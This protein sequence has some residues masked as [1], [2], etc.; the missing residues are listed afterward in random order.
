MGECLQRWIESRGVVDVVPAIGRRDGVRRG[1]ADEDIYFPI[2]GRGFL[3][4]FGS[5]E[6]A[7][8]TP[9]LER[10]GLELEFLGLELGHF[11]GGLAGATGDSVLQPRGERLGLG[12]EEVEPGV[13][14]VEGEEAVGGLDASAEEGRDVKVDDFDGC[15][16]H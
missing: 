1:G 3:V 16:V 10:A 9:N 14:A 4:L 12:F 5:P 7:T 6:A 2:G 8:L 13:G 11:F 15:D